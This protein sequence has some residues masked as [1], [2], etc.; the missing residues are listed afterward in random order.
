MRKPHIRELLLQH[1]MR[2][3]PS[4]DASSLSFRLLGLLLPV[5]SSGR[6]G[7]S[8]NEQ[9]HESYLFCDIQVH[10]LPPLC[11]GFRSV[12]GHVISALAAYLPCTCI[13]T[14]V[15]Q[16]AAMPI[17]PHAQPHVA[18]KFVSNRCCTVR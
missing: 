5:D 16:Y 18:N 6:S 1:I 2:L 13:S 4:S 15:A 14:P 11:S 9:E 17:D 10:W 12:N 8:D 3:A 7:L